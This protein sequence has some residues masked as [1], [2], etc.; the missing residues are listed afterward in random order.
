VPCLPPAD[1]DLIRFDSLSA[2]CAIDQHPNTGAF[3]LAQLDVGAMRVVSKVL[4]Q[5]VALRHYHD[6]VR[7]RG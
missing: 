3:L 2:G 1:A 7:C 5:S 6:K 4:A